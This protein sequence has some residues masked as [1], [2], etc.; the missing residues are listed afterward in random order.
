MPSIYLHEVLSLRA[1][2][3]NTRRTVSS[4]LAGVAIFGAVLL[5]GSI[6][7][8]LSTLV[9]ADTALVDV[10]R[11]IICTSS[12]PVRPSTGEAASSR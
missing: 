11:S 12:D 8:R 9:H 3:M 10:G 2:A 5:V 6:A 4:L 7:F 1:A